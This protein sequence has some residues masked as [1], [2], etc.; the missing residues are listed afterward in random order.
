MKQTSSEGGTNFYKYKLPSQKPKDAD[1][2]ILADAVDRSSDA[3][4]YIS[5]L[6]NPGNDFDLKATTTKQCTSFGFDLCI[7]SQKELDELDSYVYFAVKC[8]ETCNIN[9]RVQYTGEMVL[10]FG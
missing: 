4:I 1:F 10:E 2:S 7:L 8:Y 6:K 5:L 9:F 3:D